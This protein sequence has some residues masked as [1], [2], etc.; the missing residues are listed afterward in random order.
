MKHAIQD[1]EHTDGAGLLAEYQRKI[2][3]ILDMQKEEWNLDI[4]IRPCH[5]C[6]VP[7]HLFVH[8]PFSLV[9][10]S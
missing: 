7:T 6:S 9:I 8:F 10:F 4:V 3:P 1:V 5:L 2:F